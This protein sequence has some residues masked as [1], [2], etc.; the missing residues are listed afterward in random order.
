M[1]TNM[2]RNAS[3]RIGTT[4]VAEIT[5]WSGGPASELVDQPVFGDDHNRIH[6]FSTITYSW[7][8]SGLIDLA[9]TDGQN[10]LEIA[11]TDGTAVTTLRFYINADTY[12]TPHTSEDADACAYIQAYEQVAARGDVVRATWTIQGSGKWHRTS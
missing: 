11:A 1:G 4:T 6:G 5:E 8:M 2:G 10:Q 9:D 12:W 7:S 3:V